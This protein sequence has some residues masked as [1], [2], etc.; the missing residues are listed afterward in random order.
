MHK[1]EL[2]LLNIEVKE[3]LLEDCPHAYSFIAKVQRDLNQYQLQGQL[4]PHD[5]IHEAYE[6][7]VETICKGKKIR[8]A[9]AWLKTTCLNIVREKQRERFRQQPTDPQSR[10]FE[11]VT[12]DCGN[13]PIDES[14]PQVTRQQKLELLQRALDILSRKKPQI[15]QLL[16]WRLL[17]K[18]SWEKI[19]EQ[20]VLDSQTAPSEEA[21]RQRATR[22]KRDLRQ[23]YHKL[24]ADYFATKK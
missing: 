10:I 2:E 17:E 19:R 24:E 18:R 14:C 12:S 21:L 7:A 1:R 23:I 4:E 3:I 13:I 6:R 11:V 9:K 20:L 15:A 5:I 8:N 22:A 16:T